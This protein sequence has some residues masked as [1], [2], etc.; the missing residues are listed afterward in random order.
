MDKGTCPKDLRYVAKANIFPDEDFKTDIRSLRKEAKQ[1]FTGALTRF[2]Y[3][4][5][6]RNQDKLRRAKLH[7]PENDTNA[8]WERPQSDTRSAN[9]FPEIIKSITANLD[10]RLQEVNVLMQK[11]GR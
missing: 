6:K 11:L 2:H 5:F 8:N 4:N 1:K 3:R 10:K 9:S 7:R